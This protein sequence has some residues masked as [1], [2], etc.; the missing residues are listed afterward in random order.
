[1]SYCITKLLGLGSVFCS[2]F[3]ET[4]NKIVIDVVTDA[5]EV[6]CPCC[7]RKTKRIH[8]YRWQLVKSLP[9]GNRQVYLRLRKRRY[10]CECGKRFYEKY[11]FLPRYY[12]MTKQVYESIL[13]DCKST[14]S[15][16]DICLKHNV[17]FNT[18]IRVLNFYDRSIH[19]CPEVLSIDEFKGN[20]GGEKYNCILTDP[21]GHKVLDILQSRSQ[22]RLMDYFRSLNGR[23][24]VKVFIT[25]MYKPY[26][27][28]AK[29][30]FPNAKIV[31]DKY[32]YYRQ[33][34][35]ALERVRKRIQKQL[36]KEGRLLLKRSK[37]LLTTRYVNLTIED[38]LCVD[39]MLTA[40]EELYLAWLLKEEFL[41]IKNCKD[42]DEG[43]KFLTNWIELANYTK[44]SE[45]KDCITAFNNW[46]EYILNSLETPYTNG[47]TE[48]KNNKIKVLKRNAYGV[49]NFERFRKR[50]LLSC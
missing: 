26:A 5:H 1:M 45:F 33:V 28:L 46:F 50:I 43:S 37:K 21:K 20:T 22:N 15:Y 23:N 10:T 3:E 24:R 42:R 11:S 2:L 18:V 49:R 8:D 32:H 6:V 44:L 27:E 30:Y 35:W 41:L 34:Y 39:H 31:V 13:N 9:Y 29:I 4:S 48:G 7:G 36:S 25:D 40:H 47:F 19:K 16:K 12:R 14:C 38:K 17:S